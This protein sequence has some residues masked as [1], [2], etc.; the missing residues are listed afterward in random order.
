[1]AFGRSG[2]GEKRWLLEKAPQTSVL[3]FRILVRHLPSLLE[4][5][6][7]RWVAS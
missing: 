7:P 5:S 4:L 2:S 6:V 3:Q 1:V